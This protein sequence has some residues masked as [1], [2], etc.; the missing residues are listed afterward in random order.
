VGGPGR[1]VAALAALLVTAAALGAC[2]GPS[3]SGVASLGKDDGNGGA[4]AQDHARTRTHHGS[5]ATTSTADATKLLDEWTTCIRGHGDPNQADP[6]ID[7][8]KDIE[9]HIPSTAQTLSHEVHTGS[10][11]CS[12][13]MAAAASA[14]RGGQPPPPAPTEAQDVEFADC[15]RANGVPGYPDPTPETPNRTNFRGT[16][17]TPTSPAV[18]KATELCSKKL[19]LP[20][21]GTGR[22][23]QGGVVQVT[24]GTPPPGGAPHATGGPLRVTGGNGNVG[25]GANG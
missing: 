17:V 19:G 2:G 24:S 10:T 20:Y 11:P 25:S 14:L 23:A 12:H 5:N 9:V 15:M 8:T 3:T 16:G 4:A 7:A 22:Y 18:K 1:R 21:P 6:T 13:D